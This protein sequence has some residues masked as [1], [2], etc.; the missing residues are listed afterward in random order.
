MFEKMVQ[1]QL[2]IL[3]RDRNREQNP[4]PPTPPAAVNSNEERFPAQTAASTPAV[5][6]TVTTNGTNCAVTAE[7]ASVETPAST[8][9]PSAALDDRVRK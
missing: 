7:S 2:E 8:P 4:L 1:Q 3:R 5:Q 9:P 6:T